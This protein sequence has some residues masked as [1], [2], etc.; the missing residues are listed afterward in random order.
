MRREL[1]DYLSEFIT[2]GR[3]EL[4]HRVLNERT[5]YLTVV[6][7]DIYQSQNASAVLRSCDCFGIQDVHVIENN[8][9]FNVNSQVSLG[10]SKWLT[11]NKY[12]ELENN[13]LDAITNLKAQGYRI[14]ATTPHDNDT[15]LQDFDLSTGK[16][17]LI[18]GTELTGISD[19][20]RDNADEFLKIPMYG[21]TE[22]FNISVSVAIILHHLSLKLRST[23]LDWGLKEGE[24]EELM[25][26]WIRKTVKSYKLIEEK[27]HE[28]RNK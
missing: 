11:L 14:V 20:V 3:K 13:T 5:R 10:S 8:N 28:K 6:L 7:E 27:F 9:E 22:S 16:T 26:G 21:F 23:E 15:N 17:A 2:E 12:S 1:V 24:K 18:F 19:V 25:L 4:F